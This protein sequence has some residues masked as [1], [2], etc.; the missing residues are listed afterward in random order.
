LSV[1]NLYAEKVEWATFGLIACEKTS[2]FTEVRNG[3]KTT[4]RL[5]RSAPGRG[6]HSP[7]TTLESIGYSSDCLPKLAFADMAGTVG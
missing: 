5:R 4:Q 1:C 6:I 7:L 3:S 2:R